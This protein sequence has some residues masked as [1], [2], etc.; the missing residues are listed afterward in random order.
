MPFH[1]CRRRVAGRSAVIDSDADRDQ[2]IAQEWMTPFGPHPFLKLA[3]YYRSAGVTF[4]Y[5]IIERPRFLVTFRTTPG[6]QLGL[7]P[8]QLRVAADRHEPALFRHHSLASSS[9]VSR[10]IFCAAHEQLGM[11]RLL[12]FRLP[13]LS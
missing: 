7:E 3:P 10:V 11:C 8:I 9:R 6:D 1:K 13:N 5:P 4:K 2:R 12:H